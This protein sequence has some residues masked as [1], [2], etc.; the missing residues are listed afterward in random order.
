MNR[1]D[2]NRL[3]K[4]KGY[5]AVS[6]IF[7]THRTWPEN[8]QDPIRLRNLITEAT[9]RLLAE[10]SRRDVEPILTKL[11]ELTNALDY[12][13]FLD[14]LAIFVNQ[15]HAESFLLPFSVR[16]RVIINHT[17]ATRDIVFALNR[18]Q[19][20][21]VL[22]LSEKP[23]RLYHGQNNN[24]EEITVDDFPMFHLG[25]GGAESLPG[26][27]GIKR[28]AYRDEYDR[29]FFRHVDAALGRVVSETLLPLILVGVERNL[30]FF[31]EVTSNA[32]LV[33]ASLQ[34]SHDST[35]APELAELVWPLVKS[36]MAK[37]RQE[38]LQELGTAAA[39]QRVAAGVN[40]IWPNAL[41]G[42]GA[43]LL[44]EQNY[45][46][47]ARLEGDGRTLLPVSNANGP[48]VIDDAVDEI[49]EVVLAKQ[50][51]VIFTD[52]GQLDEY[53]HIVLMLRY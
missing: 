38:A 36:Q 18:I 47:P 7:P 53:K 44:V 40:D 48:N 28:S 13:C 6:I 35:P 5:P 12:R 4:V 2:V 39:N 30:A 49:I 14:G 8:Q 16:E 33:T 21:W 51:K 29:K 52:D 42:R 37:K 25:P 9:K 41:D 31:L 22:V 27:F 17:F 32:R 34:G 3:I 50:G 46:Y 24:L 20:Y 26:G 23:T 10:F 45:H 11:E 15:D 1:V 19:S 43:L